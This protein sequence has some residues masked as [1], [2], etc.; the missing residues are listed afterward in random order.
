MKGNILLI[1]FSF[2]CLNGLAQKLESLSNY[3]DH[4]EPVGWNFG[5]VND[6]YVNIRSILFKGLPYDLQVRYL[7]I[8]SFQTEYV[9]QIDRDNVTKKYYVNVRRAK[10][11]I[12][13]TEDKST[14]EVE[15]WRNIISQED[16][17]LIKQLYSNAIMKTQYI[18]KIGI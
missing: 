3:P 10:Q 13:K 5:T 6:Y 16:V 9:M 2:I 15:K 12:W 18:K 4:L 14:V 8:P 17:D 7:V 1:L 11:S